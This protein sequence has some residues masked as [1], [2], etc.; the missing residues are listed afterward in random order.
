MVLRKVLFLV[1]ILLLCACAPQVLIPPV[2]SATPTPTA[3]PL[4]T[5]TPTLEPQPTATNTPTQTATP[6]P[7]PPPLF[8]TVSSDDDMFGIAI[9]YG[10]SLE[11]LKTANP[12]VIP[13]AMGEGLQLL[14][15]ITPTAPSNAVTLS[16]AISA[17]ESAGGLDVYCY[18][19]GFGGAWCLVDY[20]N[21][22]DKPL[23]NVSAQVTLRAITGDYAQTKTAILPLNLIPAQTRLPLA[24]YFNAPT[25]EEFSASARIDFSLPVSEQENRYLALALSPAEISYSEDRLSARVSGEIRFEDPNR[26]ASSVWVVAVAYDD[27]DQQVGFR[28]FEASLPVNVDQPLPF[29]INVYSLADAIARVEL[30]SEARPVLP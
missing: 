18:R 21:N 28:R 5:V 22:S 15:P 17:T 11:A 7:T 10:I 2:A 4:P 19:D 8:H 6:T 27:H 1:S 12:S 25:P 9:R 24:V 26:P 23:E 29:N 16:P 13:H 3:S 30:H 20:A 14:I